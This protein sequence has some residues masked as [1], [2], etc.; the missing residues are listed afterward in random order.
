MNK[1]KI[2]ATV[3]PMTASIETIRS[4]IINGADVIRINMSHASSSFCRE[5]VSKVNEINEELKTFTSIMID[6]NGPLIRLGRF[7][8]GKAFLKKNDKIRIF[9]YDVLGDCTK[10]ST[11]YPKLINDVT[12]N[13]IIKLDNGSVELEVVDKGLDYIL[14]CVIKEGI[15][16]DNKSLNVI[17]TN[18]RKPYLTDDDKRMIKFAHEI[19]ADFL[20]LSYV[21][22]HEDIL[23]VSDLLIDIGDDHINI[24]SK[25][26]NSQA[27]EDI[28]NIIK[29]SDG[30]LIERGDLGV[31]IATEKIPGI[32]KKIINKCHIAGKISIVSTEMISALEPTRAEV[33]DVANAILDGS[34]A[35]MMCG[36]TTMGKYQ[37]E[38]IKM[39]EKIISSAEKDINYAYFQEQAAK[40][41]NKDTTGTLA[42]SVAGCTTRLN[43]KA[44]FTPTIS[45]Y[46]ARKISRFKP[47][48]PIVAIS[49]DIN[50]VKSLNLN[51]GVFPVLIDELKTLD[52]IIEKSKKVAKEGLNLDSGDTIIITGGYPFKKV[53]HTNFIKIEEL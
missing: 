33:S 16:S 28:D 26:E 51:F 44:I 50:T 13:T 11:N 37:I 31:E 42:Y 30:I 45:G 1:T 52:A 17:G 2:I 3:G 20:G 18:L 53:K 15:V 21:S 27:I 40:T 38:T 32:Q 39:I 14:C 22:S 10:F 43:C 47:G 7:S 35:I 23:D 41:E 9:T 5:I 48:C 25:I 49:P 34:D 8:N 46:T 12:Y 24:I 4:L 19:K 6:I 29:S 36:E